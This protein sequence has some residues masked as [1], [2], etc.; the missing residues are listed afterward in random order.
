MVKLTSLEEINS[1][2]LRLDR[3]D[4]L[5]F[6]SGKFYMNKISGIYVVEKII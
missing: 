5:I 2:S 4:T 6:D 1:Y 3:V